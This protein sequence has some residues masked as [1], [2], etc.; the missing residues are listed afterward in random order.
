[1]VIYCDSV[2]LMYYFD[3]T[4]VFN[5]RAGNRMAAL[6]AAG[7][8]IAVSDLV[9]LECRVKPMQTGDKAKLAVYDAFFA[10]PELRIVPLTTAAYDRATAIRAVYGFKTIDAIHLAAA[11]EAGCDDFLTNDNRLNKFR[12][13]T[14]EVLP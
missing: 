10:R 2:I 12:D 14:V 13:I 8:R 3:H 11:A 9:R 4:G 6:L 1:M 5:V 7:D